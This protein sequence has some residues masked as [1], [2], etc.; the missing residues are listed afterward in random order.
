MNIEYTQSG[1]AKQ[2]DYLMARLLDLFRDPRNESRWPEAAKIAIN[3]LARI[4]NQKAQAFEKR[5]LFFS[6]KLKN[7][8]SPITLRAFA[9][10]CIDSAERTGFFA[11]LEKNTKVLSTKALEKKAQRDL[12]WSFSAGHSEGAALCRAANELFKEEK[13]K[14]ALERLTKIAQSHPL[15]ETFETLESQNQHM[16]KED[17][18]RH[19]LRL[20]RAPDEKNSGQGTLFGLLVRAQAFSSTTMH[21]LLGDELFFLCRPLGFVDQS[22]STVLVEVPTSAHLHAL[23]Y[24]KLDIVRALKKDQ[25][26]AMVKNIKLKVTGSAFY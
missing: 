21:K 3:Q 8:I 5:F 1:L 24:R 23:A 4:N 11:H 14:K 13:K 16:A 10:E 20:K 25:A 12:S 7:N 6:G 22:S 15:R 26:F 9:V 2:I 19:F 18:R 17:I